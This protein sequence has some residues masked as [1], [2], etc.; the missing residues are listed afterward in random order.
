M[1]GDLH[2]WILL[3]D[4][5]EGEIRLFICIFKNME[6]ISN[7]LMIMDTEEKSNL[8]HKK[9]IYMISEAKSTLYELST[10]KRK[11]GSA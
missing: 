9:V 10:P 4:F 5:N 1:N 7:G 2:E 6:E 3:E 8:L 11:R